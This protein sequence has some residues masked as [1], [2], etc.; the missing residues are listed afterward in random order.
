MERPRS[1]SRPVR[2]PAGGSSSV[3]ERGSRRLFDRDE[4]V[5][6]S[7]DDE[8][9][10]SS[11]GASTSSTQDDGVSYPTFVPRNPGV[12]DGVW[13]NTDEVVVK[14][15]LSDALKRREAQEG[16]CRPAAGH[17]GA[18]GWLRRRAAL[19]AAPDP[20]APAPPPIPPGLVL[21]GKGTEELAALAQQ[22][23]QAAYRGQQ[24]RA[25]LL[26]G[27]R[28]L[29]QMTSLSRPFRDALAAAGART[30]RSILHHSVGA[31]DGTRKFLLQLQDGRLVEAV[32]IPA[33]EGGKHRLTVCVSSQVRAGGAAA[34][35]RAEASCATA[36][37]PACPPALLSPEQ[38]PAPGARCAPWRPALR[39]QPAAGLSAAPKHRRLA[40]RCAAPSVPPARAASHAT[41]RPMK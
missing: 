38:L 11:Q 33:D 32:G 39:Q 25:A 19:P 40:A 21:L 17:S 3:A 7:A 28:S 2:Q 37:P 15:A 1:G 14:Q 34:P 30:G 36:R 10:S 8:R 20:P 31:E 13:N 24:I 5:N 26:S 16:E 22:L 9:R 4:A 6:G 12:K 23:G 27:A 35:L 18:R 41:W 29:E